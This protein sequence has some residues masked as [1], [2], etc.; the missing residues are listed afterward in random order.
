M[1]FSALTH[2]IILKTLKYFQGKWSFERSI[3]KPA[4][5]VKG[6]ATFTELSKDTLSYYEFG[7]YTVDEISYDF[8]QKRIFSLDETVLYIYKSDHSLLHKFELD[9]QHTLYPV[10]LK[11]DHVCGQDTYSCTIILKE[12]L[13]FEL[14]YKISGANKDKM[15]TIFTKD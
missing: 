10:N 3:S 13:K 1:E 4:L 6:T 2:D 7:T 12:E 9:S 8:F 11:H 5:C 14:N 15:R